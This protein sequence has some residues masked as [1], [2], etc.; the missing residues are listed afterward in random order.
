MSSFIYIDGQD[1]QDYLARGFSLL[2]STIA[3][4]FNKDSKNPLPS[5][6]TPSNVHPIIEPVSFL[7]SNIVVNSSDVYRRPLQSI[8]VFIVIGLPEFNSGLTGSQHPL[9]STVIPYIIRG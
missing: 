8:N 7:C 5:S 9:K 3:F 2:S 6:W 4:F 1:K